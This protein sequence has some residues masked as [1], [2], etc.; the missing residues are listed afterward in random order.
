MYEKRERERERNKRKIFNAAF[1]K[2]S[3]FN[4][5]Q[6]SFY[7]FCWIFVNKYILKH[8]CNQKNNNRLYIG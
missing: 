8:F 1:S 6:Q 7:F 5:N 4:K 3:I 2:I